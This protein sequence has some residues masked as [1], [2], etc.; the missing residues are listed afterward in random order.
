MVFFFIKVSMNFSTSNQRGSIR[1][2]SVFS[3]GG[4]LTRDIK[5][6]NVIYLNMYAF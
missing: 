4:I 1:H 3:Y 2:A 5:L 6:L